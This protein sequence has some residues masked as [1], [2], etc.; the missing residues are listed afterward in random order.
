MTTAGEWL[1]SRTP[2]PPNAL[3][4]RLGVLLANEQRGSTAGIAA[5][6]FDASVRLLETL[7][8]LEGSTRDSALDLL[9][10]DALMTYAMEA[11]ADDVGALDVFAA[12]A[13]SRIAA[14][15]TTAAAS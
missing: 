8:R 15:T 13:M 9:A 12:T 14:I 1:Q 5:T 3:T 7:L 4:A 10:A 2:R 6:L 11:A